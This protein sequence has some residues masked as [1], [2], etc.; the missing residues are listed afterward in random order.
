MVI[1]DICKQMG[2]LAVKGCKII[3]VGCWAHA[4]RYFH[5]A[6]KISKN[7]LSAREGLKRINDIYRIDN[8]LKAMNL[9]DKEYIKLR[10]KEIDPEFKKFHEWLI[11]KQKSVLPESKLGQAI[12]YTLKEWPK[13]TRCI[14]QPFITLDNNKVENAIRPFVLGRKNW[15]FNNTQ[16]GAHSSACIY[17]LI[18]TA[19]ANGLEPFSYLTHLLNKLPYAE[20]E[21]DLRNLIPG[22]IDAEATG[23]M[24][25]SLPARTG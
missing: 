2:E 17:S 4:R 16:L 7:T 8:Q 24:R 15:L 21:D 14:E 3:H 25:Y 22:N 18:E 19:K 5:E 23:I 13:L 10:K 20:S 12:S 9:A 1:R 11:K 6:V